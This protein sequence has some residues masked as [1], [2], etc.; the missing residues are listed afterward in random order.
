VLPIY[1]GRHGE[2]GTIVFATSLK[3]TRN[4]CNSASILGLEGKLPIL[5]P[6]IKRFLQDSSGGFY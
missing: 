4:C 6:S 2:E 5:V 3:R 1:K